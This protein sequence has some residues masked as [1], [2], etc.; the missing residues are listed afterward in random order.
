MLPTRYLVMKGLK[1]SKLAESDH[2]VKY[3]MNRGNLIQMLK[4]ELRARASLY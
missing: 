1:I 4:I 3:F 2:N